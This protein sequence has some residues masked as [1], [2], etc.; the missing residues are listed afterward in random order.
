M[1]RIPNPAIF[2]S[3]LQDG[4]KKLLFS[5][6]FCL[7]VFEDKKTYGSWGSGSATLLITIQDPLTLLKTKTWDLLTLV[8][9]KI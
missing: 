4:N 1:D 3:D 2:V 6:F 9:E 7:L 8:F 5:K